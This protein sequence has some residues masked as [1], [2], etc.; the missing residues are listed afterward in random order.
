MNRK[1]PVTL[2]AG[3]LFFST[4]S[5]QLPAVY[6]VNAQHL[7]EQKKKFQ[8]KDKLVV[9]LTDT[10]EQRALAL[11]SM[12]P[13]SVMDKAFTPA[14]GSKHDYMSQAPYFW[15]DSTRPNGLPYM[16][17][18]GERNPEINKITDHKSLDE[19]ES[20]TRILSLAWYFTNKQTYAAKAVSL[21]RV[22]F[23]N[24]DTKMNPHLDYAQGIPG[25]TNGRGIGIIETRSLTNIADA[26]GLLTGSQSLT[27]GDMQSLKKWYTQYLDWLLTSKNGK[28]ENATK[29]NHGVWFSVQAVGLALFTGDTNKA[30]E[31]AKE[32]TKRIDSQIDK[33]G[34]MPLELERTNALSYTNFNLEAWFDLATLAQHAGVDLWHY[35]NKDG[36]GI[37]A[38]LDW[39]IPYALGEKPWPYQQISKYNNTDLYPILLQAARIYNNNGYLWYSEKVKNRD[40]MNK[41]L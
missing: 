36:A 3:L 38:A 18:D 35:K 23:I 19:I 13:A 24:E 2:F 21:L 22:F 20:A 7:S 14:S 28:E 10:L 15:Y 6:L 5:A 37:Q 17:R 12:K 30:M 31:L 34:K 29:N 33:E 39:F 32:A 11:L 1:L 40:F 25:I 16:R 26:I 8:Q 4:L 27:A 41:L 9:S